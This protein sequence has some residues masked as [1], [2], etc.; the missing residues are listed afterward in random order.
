MGATSENRVFLHVI[1]KVIHPAHIP[2]IIKSQPL[3][4]H[5]TRNLR[6]GCG[7]FC[8]QQHIRMLFLKHRI[9]MFQ[10]FHSFQIFITSVNIGN[11]FPV[12]LAVIQIQHGSHCV[13]AYSVCMILL[14]PE[15]GICNE[16]ILHLRA[17]I[18]VNQ[19]APVRVH[20]LPWV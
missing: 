18:I 20:A 15:Q 1:Y 11:P 12:V 7:F 14:C 13:H 17:S 8:N 19:R 5:F 4:F 16:E 3:F 9:Q 6:P 2:F 10:K